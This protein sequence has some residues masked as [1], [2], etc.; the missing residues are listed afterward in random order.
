MQD[1]LEIYRIILIGD[2]FMKKG[3]WIIIF[4]L[5]GITT[6]VSAGVNDTKVRVEYFE[7]TYANFVIDDLFYWHQVGIP[8]MNGRVSFCLEPGVWLTEYTYSS[9]TD[10]GIKNISAAKKHEFGLYAHYGYEYPN[11]KTKKYYLATQELIWRGLGLKTVYWSTG[12]E[13]AGDVINVEKEK[14]EILKL[15]A[16]HEKKPSFHNQTFELKKGQVFTVSDK[17]QVLSR[18]QI[19]N[20]F[21]NTVEKKGND[22]IIKAMN[23]LK[24]TVEMQYV[25]NNKTS[26]LY[27][28]ENSQTL[29]ALGLTDKVKASFSLD[30]KA[31]QLSVYKKDLDH[32]NNVAQGEGTLEGAVYG[33]FKENEKV[34]EATTDQEGKAVFRDLELGNYILKEIRPSNG[35]ELDSKEYP[36]LIDENTSLELTKEVYEK[37]IENEIEI[38]K[39]YTEDG[40]GILP[41]EKQIQFSIYDGNENLVKTLVTDHTGMIKCKLP[42][43]TYKVVQDTT[44]PGYDKVKD[45]FITVSEQKTEPVRYVLSDLLTRAKVKIKKVDEE[46]N[47]IKKAGISFKI[48]NKETQE[49]IKQTISYPEEKQI[50]VFETDKNGE[51]LLPN[52]LSYGTYELEEVKGPSG[53]L[54]LK[55]A[56]FFVIDEN[57]PFL[58]EGKDHIL[59]LRVVNKLPKGKI[60][61]VKTGSE[62]KVKEN[63]NYY[64]QEEVMGPLSGVSF[65]VFADEDI[66]ENQKI[67]YQKGDLVDSITTKE[68][69]VLT[70]ELPLGSYC[71][72]ERETVNGYHLDETPYCVTLVWDH[73]SEVVLETIHINNQK[74][75]TKIEIK[76][77]GEKMIAIENEQGKYTKKA[78]PSI[79]FFLENIDSISLDGKV[80]APSKM[81]MKAVTSTEGVALFQGIPFGSYKIYE[82]PRE[83]Y[84]PLK[85]MIVEL[86]ENQRVIQKEVLN[87][88]YKGDLVIMKTDSNTGKKIGGMKVKLLH[89]ESGIE[90]VKTMKESGILNFSN[91]EYGTYE[92][93]EEKAPAG[94]LKK[95]EHYQVKID[96]TKKNYLLNI[97]N[98]RLQLPD[99]SRIKRS[100]ALVL[101]FLFGFG[102]FCLL[103]SAFLKKKTYE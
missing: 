47:A 48:K 87:E 8:Y 52:P 22:L 10:F 19:L 39:V 12:A 56:L 3:I 70:K 99:T 81:K 94:Y 83:E 15:V 1:F 92:I 76:K 42:Y 31:F 44:T 79:S 53:Y 6:S 67:I 43:G 93:V 100:V 88:K 54:P 85:E 9:Y 25:A 34:S 30:T 97:K 59:E 66:M 103:V 60:G 75:E 64:E 32:L 14:Q 51:L 71:L 29:A 5:L 61:I 72:K 50:E 41:I 17:N 40:A 28:K 16:N 21:G 33:L 73:K 27:V 96:G 38:I 86:T 49:Y 91:L 98:D 74:E 80:I 20:T 36:I 62:I 95:K 65:D 24:T 37:V 90:V 7:D 68:G 57:T 2:E 11:H 46:G 102:F 18:F 82:E 4:L 84:Q 23:P 35:Y 101:G 63:G 69:R 26:I 58:E 78:L 89:K 77:V 45:F 13:H 55:E